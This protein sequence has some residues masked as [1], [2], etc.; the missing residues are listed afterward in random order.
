VRLPQGAEVSGFDELL[1]TLPRLKVAAFLSGCEQADFT[2]V[3][4][5][6]ELSRPTLSKT[7]VTLEEAGYVR[8]RKGHVGRRPRT[9]LSLTD[10]GAAAFDGHM[11]AVRLLA[12]HAA[13]D[14]PG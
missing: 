12:E 3:A 2:T 10:E 11:A 14:V 5:A 1:A 4:E 9:W 6:C 8:V 13:Q 7:V